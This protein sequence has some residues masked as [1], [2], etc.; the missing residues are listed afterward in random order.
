[1]TFATGNSLTTSTNTLT[2]RSANS[3][4]IRAKEPLLPKRQAV[5]SVIATASA[6]RLSGSNIFAPFTT[7]T[8]SQMPATIQNRP[9]PLPSPSPIRS[10][11]SANSTNIPIKDK[12]PDRHFVNEGIY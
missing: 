1:M 12:G 5:T 7:P 2:P 8:R 3:S 6:T 10:S 9:S 11:L 4:P